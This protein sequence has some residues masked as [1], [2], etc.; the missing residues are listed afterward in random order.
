[1]QVHICKSRAQAK[2]SG[3]D[4]GDSWIGLM[5]ITYSYVLMVSKFSLITW[6]CFGIQEIKMS[7]SSPR[8][9]GSWELL[10]RHGKVQEPQHTQKNPQKELASRNSSHKDTNPFRGLTPSSQ[11]TCALP[12]GTRQPDE[13]AGKQW[14][15]DRT[16]AETIKATVKAKA[17]KSKMPQGPSRQTQPSC[18]HRCPQA[19][20]VDSKLHSQGLQAVP[21]KAQ[22]SNQS[23]GH[24]PAQ[25][26]AS[27]LA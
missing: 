10:C 13:D 22:C 11:G 8:H 2:T 20:E 1:M 26:Q 14:E 18:F 23:Q 17:V 25:A 12:R 4:R 24:S 15:G 9:F 7:S 21:T 16:W 5:L 19:W 3:A 27:A 6:Y